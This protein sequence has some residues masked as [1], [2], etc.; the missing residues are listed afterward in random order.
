MPEKAFSTALQ[1][2]V[3]TGRRDTAMAREVVRRVAAGQVPIRDAQALLL[4]TSDEEWRPAR[5]A[6][7][8][9]L[10]GR[11]EFASAVLATHAQLVMMPP[12]RAV[13]GKSGPSGFSCRAA[14]DLPTG[15]VEGPRRHGSNRKATRQQAMLA[16][17]AQ[18]AGME[19]SAA[20]DRSATPEAPQRVVEA[21]PRGPLEVSRWSGLG[22][23]QFSN[24]LAKLVT[25]GVPEPGLQE[26]LEDRALV[27]RVSPKDWLVVLT[28]GGPEWQGIKELALRTTHEV[29]G[30]AGNIMNLLRQ[31]SGAPAVEYREDR[32]GPAHSPEFEFTA[33]LDTGSGPVSGRP[34][35]ATVKK[36]AQDRALTSLLAV[37]SGTPDPRE[38]DER[39]EE[40]P[41]ALR[42]KAG[43]N[44]LVALNGATVAGLVTTPAY[45]FDILQGM[46]RCRARVLM[47]GRM[48]EAIATASTKQDAKSAAVG[49]LLVRLRAAYLDPDSA[50][51]V[52]ETGSVPAPRAEM[53]ATKANWASAREA[54]A[55]ALDSG[56][57][58]LFHPS[59][60]GRLLVYR[61]DGTPVHNAAPPALLEPTAADVVLLGPTGKPWRTTVQ[62]WAA[63]LD[64]LLP[65]LTGPSPAAHPSVAGWATVARLALQVVAAGA[66]IPSIDQCG[67]DVWRPAPSTELDTGLRR[68][69]A[70]LPP[71][72]HAVTAG[73]SPLRIHPALSA[74]ESVLDDL[75]EVLVR[76]PGAALLHGEGAF[77]SAPGLQDPE[78]QRWADE[79]ERD[80][81]PL[82]EPELV[83]AV[84]APGPGGPSQR[85]G[86]PV[87]LAR[88]AVRDSATP[89]PLALGHGARRVLRRGA[90]SWPPL[91]RLAHAPAPEEIELSVGEAAQLLGAAA[92]QLEDAG[93]HLQWPPEL[94]DALGSYTV[95][96]SGSAAAD[97]R[98]LTMEAML[99]WR[100]Q[101]TID[102][103]DLT[104]AEM[105][106]LA[107]AVRPLVRLRDRWILA[108]PLLLARA[109]ARH[110]GQLPTREA[111]TS[112]L[113]G[114]LLV[115]GSL[116]PCRPAGGLAA[117][118]TALR[119]GDTA[120][121]PVQPPPGLTATLRPYQ[122]RGFQW[123][124]QL[125]G[126]HLNPLL[127]DDMGLGK[128][129]VTLA[130]VLHRRPAASRPV[131]VI[132]PTSL[133]DVW[134]GEAAKFSPTL[135]VVR[136]H[137]PG[138]SLPPNLAAGTLVVTTYGT[139]VR[140]GEQ[141][142]GTD[143]DLVVADEAHTINSGT[144]Q[145]SAAIRAL[146]ADGRLAVTGTPVENRS[147]EMWALQDWLNPG[148]LG[149]RKAFRER[150]GR[151]TAR[152][153]DG[154]AAQLLRR[155][156]GP[157]V[158][159]RLKTDPEIAPDLPSKVQMLH[160][161]AL[162][163]EG[164]ALY[165][166]LVRET[167]EDLQSRPR[168]A[169]AGRVLALLQGLRTIV[170]DPGLYLGESVEDIAADLTVARARSAKLDVL[171]D[172]VAKARAGGEQVIVCVN[173]LPIGNLLTACLNAAGH[174]AEFFQGST[175]PKVRA[176]M[177]ED[178]Q[179]GRLPVLVLSVRAGGTGLTLTAATEVIHFDSPW[180]STARDQASDRAF[181]IGQTRTVHIRRLVARG[182]VEERIERIVTHKGTLADAVL[183]AGENAFADM[184]DLDLTALVTLGGQGR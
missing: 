50:A 103:S 98:G 18:L 85:D 88:L 96:G 167:L 162:S 127:A 140:D 109:R 28:K 36:T 159:R 43:I 146:T 122:Q 92:E 129:L 57:A 163:T 10:T 78:V 6:V 116:V 62:A 124:V 158:L 11:P 48:V 184:D 42:R 114:S 104:E 46:H 147:E 63:P 4:G 132:C 108:A 135:R 89:G 142:A 149:S 58:V 20:E 81:D 125:S 156:T 155:I 3:E 34:Q 37:I 61:P 67:R 161:V 35:R 169:R 139:L 45:D 5:E 173:Y 141:L 105:D 95:V 79:V 54:V 40:L 49:R 24:A 134:E 70:A 100:W 117:I 123:L 68:V 14:I 60:P 118:V 69:A 13:E 111:L 15:T 71:F 172:L 7:L 52:P 164:A 182:T 157:F 121:P 120:S 86:E 179:A 99:D 12:A 47:D 133:L 171:L 177:V 101:L 87:L 76:G 115:D 176:R 53:S 143:W 93:I 84:Q 151:H 9:W 31:Q 77:A 113:A 154:D 51:P 183:P 168:A 150:I 94:A 110:L 19:L 153:A 39:F 1:K 41:K 59:S 32:H 126:L 80:L 72:A 174:R 102:G 112:A 30:L 73:T 165:E 175:P 23:D 22:R 178:F 170:N 82:P 145:A 106:L 8:R 136:Y 64:L 75:V 144:S 152:D 180:T 33:S 56:C 90:A 97:G 166:A 29:P 38:D 91:A 83:L 107:E 26:E 66:V 16:L 160:P 130:Y 65:F 2:S 27:G 148:L 55:W 17:L 138:R 181:R 128:T 21:I 131:L 74:A 119:S 44:P 137:G 25:S